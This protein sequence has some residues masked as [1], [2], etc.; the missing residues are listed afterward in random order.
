MCR[1]GLLLDSS[2]VPKS[3]FNAYV[4]FSL[5]YCAPVWLLSDKSHLGLMDSIVRSAEIL[6]ADKLC[7]LAHRR[8]VSAFYLLYEIYHRVDHPMNR[9]LNHFVATRNTRAAAALGE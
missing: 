5:K 3:C 4:L 2:R 8:K 6:F 9:Y 7:C 1:A